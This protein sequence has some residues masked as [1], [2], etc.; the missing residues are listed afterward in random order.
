MK[1]APGGAL[2]VILKRVLI[3]DISGIKLAKLFN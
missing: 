3:K 2:I 1:D